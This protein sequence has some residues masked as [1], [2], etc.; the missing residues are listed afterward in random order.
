MNI[1]KLED[2]SIR[3]EYCIDNLYAVQDAIAN[4]KNTGANYEQAVFFSCLSFTSL[5]KELQTLVEQEVEEKRLQ[6][7]VKTE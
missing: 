5:L 2:L 3:F 6:K 4:S 1:G 7:G